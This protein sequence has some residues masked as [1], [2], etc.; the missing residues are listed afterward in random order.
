MA[1]STGTHNQGPFKPST[2]HRILGVT[3]LRKGQIQKLKFSVFADFDKQIHGVSE[4]A[5]LKSGL[6]FGL[7]QK[8]RF[9]F[10]VIVAILWSTTCGP[11][12]QS[13]APL[14]IIFVRI[15]K[16][17]HWIWPLGSYVGSSRRTWPKYTNRSSHFSCFRVCFWPALP[18]HWIHNAHRKI[19]LTFCSFEW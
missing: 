17:C 19:I 8:F 3:L 13:D 5:K 15:S 14:P 18:K 6:I 11:D 12:R 4:P 2:S 16:Q 9:R 10:T 7:S 1:K